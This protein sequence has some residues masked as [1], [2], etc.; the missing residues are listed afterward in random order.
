MNSQYVDLLEAGGAF[1]RVALDPVPPAL[2]HPK[3]A[4]KEYLGIW[5]RTAAAAAPAAAL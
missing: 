3:R 5:E 4:G 2:S 1:R